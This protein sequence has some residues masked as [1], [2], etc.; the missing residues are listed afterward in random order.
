MVILHFSHLRLFPGR[1][2]SFSISTEQCLP[3]APFY[4]V[5]V[6]HGSIIVQRKI[7]GDMINSLFNKLKKHYIYIE[8]K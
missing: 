1:L 3:P 6:Q 8:R 5:Q 2:S 7:G 4:L